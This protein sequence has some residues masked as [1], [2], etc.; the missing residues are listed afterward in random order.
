[1]FVHLKLDSFYA[2]VKTSTQV[3]ALILMLLR[4]Q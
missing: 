1:V 3:F 2:L 4:A